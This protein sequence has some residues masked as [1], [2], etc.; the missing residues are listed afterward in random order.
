MRSVNLSRYIFDTGLTFA[1]L[2]M[3]ADGTIYHRFGGRDSRSP[4][5]WLS[6]PSLEAGMR[7][8][9][10]AHASH[11]ALAAVA[12]DPE[13]LLIEQV[14]SYIKRDKGACI[15]CH[16]IRPALYEEQL[17]EGS[18]K[19]DMIWRYLPPS[20]IGLDLDR[21]DQRRVIRVSPDSAA[22]KAGIQAGDLLVALSSQRVATASDVMFA[23]DQ[24][25]TEGGKLSVAYERSGVPGATKL[26][27]A[28]GWK[29]VTAK[30]FSWRSFKWGLTPAP[31][32]GGTQLT[33]GELTK[34]GLSE[35]PEQTPFAF[36][37]TYLVTWGDNQ[38]FGQA[39]MKAGLREGDT[40]LSIRMPGSAGNLMRDLTSVDHFHAWWRLT[41][42]VGDVVTLGILR[43]GEQ[44]EIEL[45]VLE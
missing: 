21:D 40:L 4:H 37:V 32:F 13:P 26:D 36:R 42:T 18:W 28:P 31:G 27:L 8:G 2:W 17:A 30:E 12:P 16:S 29:T 25:P 10:A 35:P 14:P 23:L 6:L 38:R 20:Q 41:A 9:L 43:S 19:R 3:N 44:V 45:T 33:A 15:H 7:A 24:F 11:E 39:A 34:L 22:H 1:V 5:Q